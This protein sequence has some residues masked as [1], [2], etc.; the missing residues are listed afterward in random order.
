MDELGNDRIMVLTVKQL[1]DNYIYIIGVYQPTISDP[2]DTFNHTLQLLENVLL[3][4]CDNGT[5]IVLGDFNAHIGLLAGERSFAKTNF[6]GR[7][8]Y[9]ILDDS[10]LFSINS[11]NMCKGPIETFYASQGHIKTTIDYIFVSKEFKSCILESAVSEDCSTNLS[12]HLPVYCELWLIM[13]IKQP[14]NVLK[15][16]CCGKN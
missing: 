4:F 5:V 16:C 3:Q 9:R 11:L 13:K 1:D 2:V 7:R 14:K 12:Y 10:E 6:R 8:V 15:K